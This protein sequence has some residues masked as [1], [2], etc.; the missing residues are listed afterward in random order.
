MGGGG[1]SSSSSKSSFFVFVVVVVGRVVVGIVLDVGV[2]VLS[3]R[4]FWVEK[5]SG[6][7]RESE[8]ARER[9]RERERVLQEKGMDAAAAVAGFCWAG[10]SIYPSAAGD[11]LLLVAAQGR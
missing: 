11:I 3:V 10:A 2:V 4:S 6:D 5:N 7:F 8:R 1:S 9:E